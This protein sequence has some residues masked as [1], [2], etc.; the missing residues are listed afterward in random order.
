MPDD[1]HDRR[2]FEVSVITMGLDHERRISRL[3][4]GE[5]SVA[6]RDEVTSRFATQSGDNLRAEAPITQ[7]PLSELSGRWK[8]GAAAIA[9]VIAAAA[10]GLASLVKAIAEALK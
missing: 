7:R 1:D 8:A 10:A 5:I 6:V 3:E 2:R 4:K 9:I